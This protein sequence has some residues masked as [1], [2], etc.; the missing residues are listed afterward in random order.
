MLLSLRGLQIWIQFASS[1]L[2]STS[3][4][5]SSLV[6]FCERVKGE[7]GLP[8]TSVSPWGLTV[9]PIVLVFLTRCDAATIA[10]CHHGPPAWLQQYLDNAWSLLMLN[11]RLFSL[12][13]T[14][15]S[16]LKLKDEIMVDTLPKSSQH[17]VNLM[18]LFISLSL[19][20]GPISWPM[21]LWGLVFRVKTIVSS[22]HLI[23]CEVLLHHV[24]EDIWH[25]SWQSPPVHHWEYQALDHS[26]NWFSRI[27]G[28][29]SSNFLLIRHFS[30][31]ALI[32]VFTH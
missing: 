21:M 23:L 24:T 8:L 28:F 29:N 12:A 19:A 3:V 1:W 14:P 16:S 10:V 17:T 9:R 11:S 22:D 7:G 6:I 18:F 4:H 13:E 30:L 20:C 31:C 25:H 2:S 26:L 5:S 32:W 15:C 27:R